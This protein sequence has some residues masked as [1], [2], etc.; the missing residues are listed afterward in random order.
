M[1]LGIIGCGQMG[2]AL[3]AGWLSKGVV[4]VSDVLVAD[5]KTAEGVASGLGVG[6]A[7][8]EAVVAECE[9]VV[10]AV[11]PHHLEAATTGLRFRSEQTVVSVLAGIPSARIESSVAPAAVVRTMPN[12]AAQV[13]HA[14]T[15][16][17]EAERAD[18][19]ERLFDAVGHV[20]RISDE[21]LFHAATGLAG[22]GPAYLFVAIEAL[23]DAAVACGLS[24]D[25]ATRVAAHTVAGAGLLAVSD[26]RHPAQLKDAVASPGGTTIHALRAL[27]GAGFRAALIEAVLAAA[28]RSQ[29]LADS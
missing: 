25:A 18:V 6:A 16:V 29:E 10:L 3:L 7:S 24:R 23:A 26:G 15:F 13:G 17:L 11:K 1:K 2:R 19:A 21:R 20:E 8:P 27:E 14:V 5:P 9:T 22:S 4:G 28:R 12:V